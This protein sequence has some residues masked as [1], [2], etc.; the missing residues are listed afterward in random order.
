MVVRWTLWD[1]V[2]DETWEMQVN[3]NEGGTPDN[4]KNVAYSNTSAPDGGTLIYEGRDNPQ[5]IEWS[6]IILTQEHYDD[7]KYWFAKRRQVLLTNDLEEE[8]WVYLTKFSPKRQRAVH[9]P[10]KHE[11]S[12][13]A[14]VLDVP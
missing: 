12:V 11:Y 2:L 13:S 8:T 9:H 10:Y 7:Y 3:P 1:P 5:T 4:E 14:I 6:G